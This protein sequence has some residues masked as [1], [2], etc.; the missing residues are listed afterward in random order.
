MPPYLRRIVGAFLKGRTVF[1]VGR[2][3]EE[4]RREICCGLPQGSVRGPPLWDFG[5]N[6]VLRDVLP[7]DVGVVCYADDTLLIVHER[8]WAKASAL[9]SMGVTL[10]VRWIEGLGLRVA[11]EKIKVSFTGLGLSHPRGHPSSL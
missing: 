3:G 8:D 9:A 5:Y 11:M 7:Q 2:Y 1:Y 10:L 6:N 4:H